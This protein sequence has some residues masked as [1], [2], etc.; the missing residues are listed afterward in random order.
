MSLFDDVD[1]SYKDDDGAGSVDFNTAGDRLGV[2]VDTAV[3]I[4]VLA[5]LVFNISG[6]VICLVGFLLRFRTSFFVPVV[7]AK[8]EGVSCEFIND[9]LPLNNESKTFIVRGSAYPLIAFERWSKDCI[10]GWF[11]SEFMAALSAFVPWVS[12]LLFIN[13]RNSFW[14]DRFGSF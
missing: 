8:D 9:E 12:E 6:S 1:G 10:C 3:L 14:L 11:K 13:W 7:S 4:G 2:G 5:A